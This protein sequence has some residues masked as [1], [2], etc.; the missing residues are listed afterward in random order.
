VRKFG[1]FLGS[2]DIST[3]DKLSIVRCTA[4]VEAEAEATE[5]EPTQ[6]PAQSAEPAETQPAEG[7]QG[8]LLHVLLSYYTAPT[9]TTSTNITF[10]FYN[11]PTSRLHRVPKREL[12][13][14]NGPGF[15]DQANCPFLH[16]QQCQN[17]E[18]SANRCNV[19][20]EIYL[21]DYQVII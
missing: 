8:L 17:T 12:F 3:S 13:G 18:G 14:I 1:T 15:K 20:K 21:H 7:P 9:T 19:L 6:E 2:P 16:N 11:W 5:V 4:G 10:R